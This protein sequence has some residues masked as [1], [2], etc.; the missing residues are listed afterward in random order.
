[1]GVALALTA[2]SRTFLQEVDTPVRRTSPSSR[3]IR[4]P[5]PR[6]DSPARPYR[7]PLRIMEPPRRPGEGGNDDD[8][9]PKQH[10]VDP[11]YSK[12]AP[13][14]APTP[15]PS[16]ITRTYPEPALL[17]ARRN[18]AARAGA[19]AAAAAAV[20]GGGGGRSS[21]STDGSAGARGGSQIGKRSRRSRDLGA[22]EGS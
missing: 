13:G 3:V 11:G 21:S 8:E 5:R 19:A 2:T 15:H 16:R 14:T 6:H 4:R 7:Q 22:H 1:K 18:A 12:F 10:W 20:V 17:I 9:D